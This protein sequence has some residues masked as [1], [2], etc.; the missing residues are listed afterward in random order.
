[1]EVASSY[2]LSKL[3]WLSKA[4]CLITIRSIYPATSSFESLFSEIVGPEKALPKAL[5][6][7]LVRI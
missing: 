6:V 3:I 5:E 7:R 2:F 1:M 4:M